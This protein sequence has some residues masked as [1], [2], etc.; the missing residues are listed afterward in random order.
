MNQRYDL[1][2]F[3]LLV[4]SVV[5]VV[6]IGAAPISAESLKQW[7][8]LIGGVVTAFGL[9]IASWN[10]TRQMRL[11]ARGREQDRVERELP[12][13]R[14]A[15]FFIARFAVAI[16]KEPKAGRLLTEFEEVGL[17]SQ[18]I[19]D[20]LSKVVEMLPTTP[21]IV[22]R[23]LAF[24]LYRLRSVVVR[25]DKRQDAVISAMAYLRAR[26]TAGRTDLTE[27]RTRVPAAEVEFDEVKVLFDKTIANFD[28]YRAKL[29]ARI[30]SETKKSD[31]LRRKLERALALDD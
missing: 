9:V 20:F 5:L 16:G 30:K 29:V 22:K 6:W 19:A 4:F 15:V 12:G 11:A 17:E 28:E 3:S 2:A 24:E 1:L 27:S 18:R 25:F 26:E 7:Q 10:V 31:I 8:T 14:A 13:L 21:D 23:E